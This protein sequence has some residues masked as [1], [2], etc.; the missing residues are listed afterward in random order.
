MEML[1]FNPIGIFNKYKY[2]P[3]NTNSLN[4]P[5][6]YSAK[7]TIINY[8]TIS[9]LP[10]NWNHLNKYIHALFYNIPTYY[11]GISHY[12]PVRNNHTKDIFINIF[13]AIYIFHSSQGEIS[14]RTPSH[15]LI[16]PGRT[17]RA[18]PPSGEPPNRTNRANAPVSLC[19]YGKNF[20]QI[21]ALVQVLLE[22]E[23]CTN[24]YIYY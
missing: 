20:R 22:F 3:I 5:C 13:I 23:I 17:H 7:S 10:L 2:L 12:L 14:G 19:C 21:D 11:T 18:N 1:F 24:I 15:M 9:C 16:V 6:F 4:Y 8:R